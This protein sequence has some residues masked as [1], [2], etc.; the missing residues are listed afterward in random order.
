MA[1]GEKG[2]AYMKVRPS[3]S[4][5]KSIHELSKKLQTFKSEKVVNRFM[6]IGFQFTRISIGMDLP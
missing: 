1:G 5:P 6:P 2:V 4:F 3:Q